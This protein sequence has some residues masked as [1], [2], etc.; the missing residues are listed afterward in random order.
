M[1]QINMALEAC[2]IFVAIG[3]SG[4]VYPAAGFYQTAKIR[5]AHT[6]E[7][8][9]EQTGSSF[10][11]HVYGPATQVVPQYFEGLLAS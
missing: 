1:N 8:N 10:D 11:T 5:R 6:V 4:N 3:T 9:L 2:D 7:L